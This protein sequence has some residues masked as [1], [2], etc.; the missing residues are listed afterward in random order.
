MS[1]PR[2]PA[3]LLPLLATPLAAQ[4][5]IGLTADNRLLPLQVG[6]T[7]AAGPAVAIS[8]LPAGTSLVGI[9]VRPATGR[10]YGLGS[11]S[12]LY[13][14]DPNTGLATAVGAPFATALSG[15]E[16]GFDF[17]PTVDR[18]RI[19]S[20]SGQN[21]RAHPD[22]GAVVAV[23]SAL[24]FAPSDPNAG[25]TPQIAA[26]GYTNSVAGATTTTLYNIDTGRDVLVTQIPP[27]SGTLNTIGSLG[28][29]VIAVAGFDIAPDGRAFAA[30]NT[31]GSTSGTTQLFALDL[32][33]GATSWLGT[34]QNANP[35]ARLRG[36]ALLPARPD[37]ELVAL[38][39]DGRLARFDRSAPWLSPAIATVSGL[40]AGEELLGIDFRPATG[41]L[42]GLGS[43]SRLYT[44]D[45]QTGVATAIGTGFAMPLLG[46]RFGFDFN[47]TV[48][49]IR[50]VSDQGQN[51]RAHPDTGALVATDGMLAYAV[52]DAGA[53][54]APA[55]AAAAYTNDL[56]GATSTLL[57]GIDSARDVLVTQVPPNNGTLNTIGMLGLDITG[58]DG[59][60]IGSDGRAFAALQDSS[61]S[62]LYQVDLATGAL[63]QLADLGL[64]IGSPVRG[65]AVRPSAGLSVF[66][67]ATAGCAGPAWLGAA[68]TPFAGNQLFAVR[69]HRGP[70]NALGFFVLSLARL[71]SPI[72]YGGLQ[73][74]LDGSMVVA[75]PTR[76]N[77]A[78]GT[79]ELSMPLQGA[80][81]GLDLYFQWIGVDACGPMGLATTAGLRVT[82]Q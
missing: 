4:N 28:R 25:M 16:F 15:S 56:A 53:G 11:N 3:L 13:V 32:G 2:F 48:D 27:N 39:A 7:L 82:V 81:F 46:T 1:R 78:A 69:S 20:D 8:G 44:I 50:I 70:A 59:F 75:M 42:Y 40:S 73:G 29:D 65:L 45:A 36:L 76:I 67:T 17:N 77:D 52:T 30:L 60:D 43:T 74:W 49:R 35:N 62:R 22:T 79:G 14:L 41:Q 72:D 33:T 10:L 64:A 9:D 24:Q 12:Q 54:M 18:I 71:S 34:L 31:A 5:L 57:Y 19:V 58:V 23:D 80:W 21:L 61:G 63:S 55:V 6:T 66:G 68:G 51:L 38:T 37:A 26:S 47:P